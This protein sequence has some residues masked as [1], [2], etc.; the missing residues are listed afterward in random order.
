MITLTTEQYKLITGALYYYSVLADEL[1]QEN[2]NFPPEEAPT[3][4]TEA[5][6]YYLKNKKNIDEILGLNG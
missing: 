1:H 4:M 6:D 3:D 2:V 5:C